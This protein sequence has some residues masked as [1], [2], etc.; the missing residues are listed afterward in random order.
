ME[1]P[2]NGQYDRDLFFRAVKLANRPPRNQARF[3]G[4]ISLFAVGAAALMTYRIVDT[5]DFAG[6]AIWLFAALIMVAALGWVYLQPYFLARRM[7]ANPGTRRTLHGSIT[8]RGIVYHLPEGRNEI[9]WERFRRLRRS[10][11][12]VTLIRDDGLLVVFPKSFFKK[13]ADWRKF[14]KLLEAVSKT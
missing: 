9:R 3:L 12:L 7:W 5:R 1:I 2:F 8:N 4:L 14:L 6:N 11:D 13:S 10:E